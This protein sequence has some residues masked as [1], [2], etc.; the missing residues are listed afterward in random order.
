MVC[1]IGAKDRQAASLALE[2]AIREKAA[3]L[4]ERLS[5]YE[6]KLA[7]VTAGIASGFKIN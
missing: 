1:S 6:K 4:D 5:D 2:M 3:N 7:V